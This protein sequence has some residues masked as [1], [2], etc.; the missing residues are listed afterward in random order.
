M[1]T[2]VLQTLKYALAPIANF[3]FRIFGLGYKSKKSAIIGSAVLLILALPLL[4]AQ[5]F[6]FGYETFKMY[7]TLYIMVINTIVVLIVSNDPLCQS[8]FLLLLQAN[9]TFLITIITNAIKHSF[10]L[11]YFQL[12]VLLAAVLAGLLYVTI[13]FCAKPLRFLVEQIKSG[14]FVMLLVPM[15]VL[16]S[17]ILIT[18]YSNVYF[19]NSPLLYLLIVCL[20]EGAFFLYVANLYRNLRTIYD[21]AKEIKQQEVLNNEI[22][23]YNKEVVM[24]RTVRHDARHHNQVLAELLHSGDVDGALE[25]LNGY[26]KSIQA[27]KNT[28]YCNNII[29]NAIFRLYEKKCST[30]RIRYYVTADIPETLPLQNNELCVLL[31]NILENAYEAC[32][33]VE[34]GRRFVSVNAVRKYDSLQLEISN[35]AP[36]Q[37]SVLADHLPSST[38]NGGGTGLI[39]IKLIVEKAGGAFRIKCADGVFTTQIILSLL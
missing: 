3:I 27:T 23:A 39:S 16:V 18:T 5:I 37:I 26:E 35:S 8:L 7:V 34:E 33:K 22:D 13:K 29:A 38:K 36:K 15:V 31:S 14:W 25:Y 9:A 21:Y 20:I 11:N 17:G 1:I 30:Y 10:G 2:M 12:T 32:Q 4:F 28:M 6:Y 19:G 24:M